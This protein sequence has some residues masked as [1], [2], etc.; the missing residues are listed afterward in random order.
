MIGNNV[1][2]IVGDEVIE[3]EKLLAELEDWA[4]QLFETEWREIENSGC[5]S[6]EFYKR[7]KDAASKRNYERMLTIE[8]LR[9]KLLCHG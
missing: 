1:D 3:I 5:T 9:E 6:S 2:M 8:K 4:V 7:E